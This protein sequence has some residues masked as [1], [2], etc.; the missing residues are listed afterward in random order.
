M[1]LTSEE[2]T[3]F[4]NG[5]NA[6]LKK[7]TSKNTARSY[8]QESSSSEEVLAK[9]EKLIKKDFI[10][11]AS[12]KGIPTP[13]SLIS[14]SSSDLAKIQTFVGYTPPPTTGKSTTSVDQPGTN[15]LESVNLLSDNI[16]DIHAKDGARD[17]KLKSHD[18][19]ISSMG[20]DMNSMSQDIEDLKATDKITESE[21]KELDKNIKNVYKILQ[22]SN[23]AEAAEIN[24][25]DTKANT[26][27]NTLGTSSYTISGEPKVIISCKRIN[28]VYELGDVIAQGATSTLGIM[29]AFLD[30][31]TWENKK[32]IDHYFTTTGDTS[33]CGPLL[34]SEL[35]FSECIGALGIAID[36]IMD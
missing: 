3:Y 16:A 28:K 23:K 22:I 32:T 29:K 14:K 19:S 9:L 33:G 20:N 6:V 15:M 27:L 36:E 24:D 8:I 35:V 11:T 13:G 21:L 4:N 31:A 18:D 10:A 26:A 34:P 7:E 25:I 12:S 1:P 30:C 5:I 17:A 2:I